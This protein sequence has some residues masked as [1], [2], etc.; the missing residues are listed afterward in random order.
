MLRCSCVYFF[1]L[2]KT[3]TVHVLLTQ[4]EEAVLFRLCQHHRASGLRYPDLCTACEGVA[5]RVT[6]VRVRGWLPFLAVHHP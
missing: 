4:G 6:L 5:T 2:L 3:S 1:N